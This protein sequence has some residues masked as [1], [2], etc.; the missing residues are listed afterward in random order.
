MLQH[1]VVE[2]KAISN[3]K[4]NEYTINDYKKAIAK[5]KKEKIG[6]L[7]RIDYLEKELEHFKPKS[8]TVEELLELF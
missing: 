1:S 2:I 6:L 8:H 4:S 3:H 7:D 5:Y